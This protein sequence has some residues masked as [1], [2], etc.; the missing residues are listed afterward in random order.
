MY[1]YIYSHI[2]IYTFNIHVTIYI[3]ILTYIY[4]IVQ[5]QV[6]WLITLGDPPNKWYPAIHTKLQKKQ[7]FLKPDSSFCDSEIATT[8][9]TFKKSF[10]KCAL[11]GRNRRDGRYHLKSMCRILVSWHVANKH[12]NLQDFGWN[13]KNHLSRLIPSSQ[14]AIIWSTPE[15]NAGLVLGG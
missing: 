11:E 9:T 1:I 15:L 7:H 10:P 3:C 13:Y 6:L 2:H 12:L 4:G 5:I 8:S 14:Y